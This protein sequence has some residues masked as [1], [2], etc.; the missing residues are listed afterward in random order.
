MMEALNGTKHFMVM[1][2]DD[3]PPTTT[4]W[5]VSLL[6]L[7]M[8]VAA[9]ST[10]L[11]ILEWID[12]RIGG[13]GGHQV[14]LLLGETNVAPVVS[15]PGKGVIVTLGLLCANI[16]WHA[17]LLLCLGARHPVSFAPSSS[18]FAVHVG[19]SIVIMLA[20]TVLM[21]LGTD[22]V[23]SPLFGYAIAILLL[24]TLVMSCRDPI[25]LQHHRSLEV[26]LAPSEEVAS[27][28]G[29]RL[30]YELMTF[31]TYGAYC[32]LLFVPL[33]SFIPYLG[34]YTVLVMFYALVLLQDTMWLTYGL[35]FA[36]GAAGAEFPR[37]V[38]WVGAICG[39]VMGTLQME[40]TPANPWTLFLQGGDVPAICIVC[41]LHFL[42]K[43]PPI[44]E[45]HTH[46][47]STVITYAVYSGCIAMTLYGGFIMFF[48]PEDYNALYT[49]M[50]GTSGAF[51]VS[52]RILCSH[53]WQGMKTFVTMS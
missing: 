18:V 48:N 20:S 14:L 10:A 17:A 15:T 2:E 30:S 43:L 5:H 38:Q 31:I 13:D 22:G 50:L 7:A 26:A 51:L 45:F 1:R 52:V 21:F 24:G 16:T 34:E 42:G 11:V 33:P 32:V 25:H 37:W 44:A 35:F 3:P 6:T 9:S 47:C 28:R 27:A 49:Y 36:L 39:L 40:L 12:R 23:S 8:V 46:P 53:S 19:L 4:R 29:A 41:T